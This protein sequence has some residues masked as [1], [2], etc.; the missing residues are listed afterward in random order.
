MLFPVSELLQN[1]DP[2][3]SIKRDTKVRD[4]LSLMVKNDFSQLP[5]VDENS[6]LVG[7][8]T[9]QSIIS[10]YFHTT[11]MVSILDLDVGHCQTKPDIVD[12]DADIFEVFDLLENTYA[13]VIVDQDKPIGILTA[14]DTTHFLRDLS[15][16]LILVEDIEVTLRH[17]IE[18]LYPNENSL[19]AALMHAF[20]AHR[21]DTTR[22]AKEY[23]ELSFG[24]HI[25]L[26]TTEKN[27]GKFSKYFEPKEMFLQLMNQVGQI[28]NQLAHFRGRIEPI[29]YD[30]LLRARD[31]LS[32]RP[33]PLGALAKEVH[34][35]EI[36]IPKL[37]RSQGKYEALQKW[38]EEQKEAG[39]ANLR[40]GFEEIEEILQDSLPS[41]AR[42]HRSWWA[43]D[44]STH[45][46]SQAWLNSGWLVDDVDLDKG[47]IV[48]RQSVSALYPQFFDTMLNQ[49]KQLRPGLTQASKVAT[50]NW[51]SLGAGRTGFSFA[52]S[53]PR[54]GVGGGA[55]RVELYIDVG[56]KK[57]NKQFF[58]S[59]RSHEK[60]IEAQIGIPLKWEKLEERKACRISALIPFRLATA[61]PEDIQEAQ[62]WG[63]A[64]MLKFMD[65]FPAYIKNI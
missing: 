20:R 24:D 59:L 55:L 33:R 25:Q 52:W 47:E 17:Y 10:T 6:D 60:E 54:E 51:L 11:G 13:I 35:E 61:T 23:A 38:L 29:Q 64:T 27:W 63:V 32:S 8:I 3:L 18:A 45:V 44:Y 48:I 28:R 16:G 34:R 46:Q 26:I 62:S 22:P 49:L 7:I 19:D 40:I 4:A 53:L 50:Q 42:T 65:V 14:Y 21:Q 43:N 56:D 5:I 39:E 41:S 15:E 12:K 9:E 36:Q 58:E 31:W 2:I 30:A 57:K 37:K 1:K